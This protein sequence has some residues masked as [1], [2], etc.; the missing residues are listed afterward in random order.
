[1]AKEDFFMANECFIIQIFIARHNTNCIPNTGSP[2]MR[3]QPHSPVK[4]KTPW[5]FQ[6]EC[7]LNGLLS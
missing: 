6:I 1:M 5:H 3:F 2:I 7:M 4:V